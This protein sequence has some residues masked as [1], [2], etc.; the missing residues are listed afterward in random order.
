MM[1]VRPGRG[2]DPGLRDHATI[3]MLFGSGLRV[4][5]L[6]NLNVDQY[7][8]RGSKVLAKGGRIRD[9]VP[10]K[11]ECAAIAR[12]RAR[13]SRETSAFCHTHRR[14]S[15]ACSS[16]AIQA[17]RNEENIPRRDVGTDYAASE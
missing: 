4:S 14:G 8:G 15:R 11:A 10:V 6:L 12:G 13:R 3:A 17:L 9:F 1:G 7:T 2:T 16:W 5:E